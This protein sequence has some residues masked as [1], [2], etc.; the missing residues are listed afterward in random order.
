[1]PRLY[2][3]DTNLYIRALRDR[4]ARRELAQFLGRVGSG[5][6]LHAVVAMELRAGAR[7]PSQQAELNSLIAADATRDRVVTRT[8]RKAGWRVVR[9]W[10]CQLA[11]KH[12]ARVLRRLKAALALR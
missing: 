9:I 8:L 2:A 4:D 6:R 1:M 10:E 5:V 7:T 3:L 12:E 11:R